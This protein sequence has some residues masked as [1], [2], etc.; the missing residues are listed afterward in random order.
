[1]NLVFLTTLFSVT[2][3][4]ISVILTPDN[5]VSVKGR[6]DR[7]MASSFISK[8]NQINSTNIYVYI[9]S[10]GGDVESGQKMIQYLNFKK[11]TNKTIMCIAWEAHSMAFNIFQSCSYRYVLPDSKMMQH[12]MSFKNLDGNIENL[13]NYVKISNKLYDKLI[14]DASKRIGISVD[15]YRAKIMNDWFLY[16]EEIVKNN[17]A[18]AMISSVGCSKKLTA[19]DSI[20]T[21]GEGTNLLTISLC[22]LV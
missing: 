7:Y 5:H 10:P 8:I 14:E 16:G 17:V 22:P 18:D 9:D 1:M 19:H 20:T 12:Q 21:L 15:I 11:D 2:I 3:Q 4:P 6:I 13:N